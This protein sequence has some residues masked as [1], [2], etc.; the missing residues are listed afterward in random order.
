MSDFLTVGDS[1]TFLGCHGRRT[2][3]KILDISEDSGPAQPDGVGPASPV[4]VEV[5]VTGS[6]DRTYPKGHVM[7]TSSTWIVTTDGKH[8]GFRRPADPSAMRLVWLPVNQAWVFLWHEQAIK[9]DGEPRFFDGRV[10][11]RR[12]AEQ[13]AT[14]KGMRVGDDGLVEIVVAGA[15]V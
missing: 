2:K 3:V 13:A 12:A 7:R 11:G 15:L 1:A 8:V 4:G 10:E 14:A 6:N 9:F 5:E